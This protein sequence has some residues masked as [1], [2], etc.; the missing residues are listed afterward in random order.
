[1]DVTHSLSGVDHLGPL[2]PRLDHIATHLFRGD[3]CWPLGSS[4][5]YWDYSRPFCHLTNPCLHSPWTLTGFSPRVTRVAHSCHRTSIRLAA[6]IWGMIDD[7]WQFGST[8]APP[9]DEAKCWSAKFSLEP[10][11]AFAS[12][13]FPPF[14][15]G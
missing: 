7:P 11:F 9:T 10:Y 5:F 4:F 1:M 14:L 15:T 6:S 3:D 8:P 12:L 2:L 13:P